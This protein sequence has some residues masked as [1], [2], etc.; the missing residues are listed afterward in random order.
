MASMKNHLST[1][2]LTAN[3][4]DKEDNSGYDLE[5]VSCDDYQCII[6]SKI[7]KNFVELPCGHAGCDGC[8]TR[9]E[10]TKVL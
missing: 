4:D 1:S 2:T 8:I 6:C 3:G 10:M 7:I 5:F 9:W